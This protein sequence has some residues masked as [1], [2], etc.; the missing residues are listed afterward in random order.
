MDL[1]QTEMTVVQDKEETAIQS[2]LAGHLGR[3]ADPVRVVRAPV[4]SQL[5]RQRLQKREPELRVEKPE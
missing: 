3:D 2:M 4:A 1:A 5:Q